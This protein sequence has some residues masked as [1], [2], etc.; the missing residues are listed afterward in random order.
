MSR[1]APERTREIDWDL[2]GRDLGRAVQR[3]I[4]NAPKAW[5]KFQQIANLAHHGTTVTIRSILYHDRRLRDEFDELGCSRETAAVWLALKDD[6]LFEYGLSA[7]HVDRGL[8]KRSWKA[9][10]V[11]WGVGASFSF[12]PDR[13]AKFEGLI[14][15]AIRACNAFDIPGQLQTHHFRRTLFPEHTHSQR[16]LEQVTVFAEARL[17]TED[18]FENSQLETKVRRKVDSISVIFDRA[19]RELDVV[20]IGGRGF[21]EDV[22]KA[23]LK[24]FSN[25]AP[26]L[27]PL[28]RRKINLRKFLE[29]PNLILDDQTRF[30]HA[31]VDEVRIFS[32]SG[33]LYTF[34]AKP[35][36]KN[37]MDV[38]YCAK[39][40]FA[41][42]SPF[43]CPGW[44]VVSAR[45]VFSV[46]PSKPGRAPRPRAVE[47]K[48]N[49]YTNLREQDDLDSYIADELLTLW[50]ILE[51]NDQDAEDD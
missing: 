50:G 40:D 36:G 49:G 1:V 17:V 7:L 34:D 38:Y 45:V 24:A 51:P 9:F 15:D 41:D 26:P 47:L 32:P 11:N 44:T 46:V 35:V 5:A 29:K 33:V 14:R 42:R 27:Q 31:K 3:T 2:Q 25:E 8:N 37:E 28:V 16:V 10:R 18:V 48:S 20:N 22:A 6:E 43:E 19:R 23:F 12:E 13:L 21:I 39:I 30:L 4:G